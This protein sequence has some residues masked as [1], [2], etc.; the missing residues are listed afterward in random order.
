M[1]PQKMKKTQFFALDQKN[2]FNLFLIITLI[3]VFNGCK[4]PEDK[5]T[6]ELKNF[7]TNFESKA[8]PAYKDYALA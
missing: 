6:E 2:I 3:L 7:V 1:E 4:T 8:A 5:M